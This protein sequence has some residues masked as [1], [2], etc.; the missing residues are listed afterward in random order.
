MSRRAIDVAQLAARYEPR[1]SAEMRLEMLRRRRRDHRQMLAGGLVLLG[2]L[3][4]LAYA[5]FTIP[6]PV[7]ERPSTT[8]DLVELGERLGDR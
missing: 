6:A 2:I 1:N 4:G 7:E 8:V 5:A 3:A